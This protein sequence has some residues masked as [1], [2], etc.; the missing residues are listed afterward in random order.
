MKTQAK[1]VFEAILIVAVVIA[2][3]AIPRAASAGQHRMHGPPPFTE[4]D[5]DGDGIVSE[6]EFGKTRSE[7][8]AA[9]A[10]AGGKMRGAATAPSFADIDTDDDGRLSEEEL[11]AAHKAHRAAMGRHGGGCRGKGK[12]TES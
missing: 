6:E 10:K 2:L 3:T 12:E 1:F 9:R 8:M 4:F 11:T 7:H 5:R